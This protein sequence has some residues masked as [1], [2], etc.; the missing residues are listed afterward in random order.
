M[1]ITRLES[2]LPLL[3]DGYSSQVQFLCLS[4]LIPITSIHDL[5]LSILGSLTS[6]AAISLTW[7]SYLDSLTNNLVKNFTIETLHLSWNPN[8][9]S[10]FSTYLDLPACAITLALF[11]ISF[12]GIHASSLFNNALAVLNIGLLTIISI[13]GFVFGRLDNMQFGKY[14]NGFEGVIKGASIV[15]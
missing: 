2:F 14:S 13:G 3:S 5:S 8:H 4:V 11:L 15:V 10:P 7:S 6:I 9:I 12:R 1:C